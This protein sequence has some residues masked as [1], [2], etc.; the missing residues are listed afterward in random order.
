MCVR[1]RLQRRCNSRLVLRAGGRR[2]A[3]AFQIRSEQLGAVRCAAW[4]P[5]FTVLPYVYTSARTCTIQYNT[6]THL[7]SFNICNNNYVHLPATPTPTPQ[8]RTAQLSSAQ[9]HTSRVTNTGLFETRRLALL[10]SRGALLSQ[11]QLQLRLRV[12]L[13]HFHKHSGD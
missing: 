12:L 1:S 4:A 9:Q 2:R 7:D 3:P 5:P 10:R 13:L 6:S 11:L 8:T